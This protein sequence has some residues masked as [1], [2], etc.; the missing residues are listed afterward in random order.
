MYGLAEGQVVEI[1]VE[2]LRKAPQ[3]MPLL[4]DALQK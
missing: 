4:P 3:H 2:R 1:E